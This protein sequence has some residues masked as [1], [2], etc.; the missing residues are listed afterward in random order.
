MLP[1]PITI[2]KDMYQANPDA[3]GYVKFARTTLSNNGAAYRLHSG[4]GDDPNVMVISHQVVGKGVATRDRHYVR[5]ET[6]SQD[7][8][9]I[10]SHAPLV[11]Y[12]VY[13]RPRNFIGVDTP[14][15][16]LMTMSGLLR[17]R[18]AGLA[19]ADSNPN[20]STFV[21]RWAGGES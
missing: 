19:S 9:I 20:W 13:D 4:G 12:V 3:N 2:Y 16:L 21:D 1:D 17:G 11:L 7:G 18:S 5:L 6:P 8:E 15:N 14:L 10:G